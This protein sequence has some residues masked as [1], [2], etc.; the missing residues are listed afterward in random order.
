MYRVIDKQRSESEKH[1]SAVRHRRATTLQTDD[2]DIEGILG[3]YASHTEVKHMNYYKK[4][5]FLDFEKR[6]NV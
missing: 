3:V 2:E 4:S 1:R 6:N 5:R